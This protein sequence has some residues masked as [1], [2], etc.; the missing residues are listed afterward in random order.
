MKLRYFVQIFCLTLLLGSCTKELKPLEFRTWYYESQ[1]DFIIKENFGGFDVSL[2][3]KP[4]EIVA[5]EG[6]ARKQFNLDAFKSQLADQEGFRFF[7]MR[8]EAPGTK[9]FLLHQIENQEEF[10]RRL[11]YFMSFPKQD[12][13][14]ITNRDT[15][16]VASFHFERGNNLKPYQS[17]LIAFDFSDSPKPRKEAGQIH[18]YEKVLGTGGIRF[19][20]PVQKELPKLILD[21]DSE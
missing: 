5:I 13:Q 20:V 1:E 17:V 12:M 21:Y 2:V 10:N 15:L 18:F 6:Q 14:F 4:S 11:Q 19:S 9:D 3:E 16:S 7:E 8:F